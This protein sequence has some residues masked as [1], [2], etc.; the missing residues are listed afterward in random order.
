MKTKL[1]PL[2][3]LTVFFILSK[4]TH[5]QTPDTVI[6][7]VGDQGKIIIQVKD[8]SK[9]DEWK[10]FDLN[11]VITH[12]EDYLQQKKVILKNDTTFL[13]TQGDYKKSQFV[14]VKVRTA[15]NKDTT[16][17]DYSSQA[18][19]QLVTWEKKQKRVNILTGFKNKSET[20]ECEF[21]VHLGFNNYLRDFKFPENSHGDRLST[22]GSRYAAV[23]FMAKSPINKN[24]TFYTMYGLELSWYNF[25]YADP[26]IYASIN[27]ILNRFDKWKLTAYYLNLPIL[28]MYDQGK[29]RFRIG[30]GPYIGYKL[31]AYTKVIDEYKNKNHH[32]SSNDFGLTDWHAGLRLQVGVRKFNMFFN[33]DI[34]TLY[35]QKFIPYRFGKYNAFSFGIIL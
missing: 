14:M 21:F 22:R 29:K 9:I 31:G 3:F 16:A 25:M 27:N 11:Q 23:N 34:T 28:L 12:L 1:K 19:S 6:I 4:N 33:Y 17:M 24:R 32:S 8:A 5:A 2:L 15:D 7:N 18:N 35:D 20:I 30:F 10:K 26:N 13:L